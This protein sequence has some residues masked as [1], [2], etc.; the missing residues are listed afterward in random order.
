MC[1]PD[2]TGAEAA[3]LGFDATFLALSVSAFSF[4]RALALF[5][6]ALTN[7]SSGG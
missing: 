2:F 4:S 5:V 6:R 1:A 3:L 7:W